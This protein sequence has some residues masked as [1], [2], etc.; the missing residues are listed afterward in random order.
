MLD[1]MVQLHALSSGH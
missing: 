1:Y